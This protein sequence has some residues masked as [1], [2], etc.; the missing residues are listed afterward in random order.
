MFRCKNAGWRHNWYP[1]AG[2]ILP[3]LLLMSSQT[4]GSEPMYMPPYDYSEMSY[5]GLTDKLHSKEAAERESAAYYL[6]DRLR[7]N[8]N[9]GDL[10]RTFDALK[11]ALASEKSI[12][13]R[14]NIWASISNMLRGKADSPSA[15]LFRD[16]KEF[17]LT[18][19]SESDDFNSVYQALFLVGYHKAE[20]ADAAV[21]A[22]LSFPR[23]L[24]RIEA[25]KTAVALNLR[26]AQPVL[27]SMLREPD[28]S[29]SLHNA[30]VRALGKIG[31]EAS[32]PE[33]LMRR[34]AVK[35]KGHSVA[36]FDMAIAE[37]K[38]RSAREKPE[39]LDFETIKEHSIAEDE[40][41]RAS[42]AHD[43]TVI[44]NAA[45][46]GEVERIEALLA[47]NPSL[48]HTT[49]S[50]NNLTPLHWAA[51]RGRL[52]AVILLLDHGAEVD[53]E[54]RHGR[55]PLLLTSDT[56]I[57][58]LLLESGADFR[59]VD[60]NGGSVLHTAAFEGNKELVEM[61]IE[62]GVD[63]EQE[64]VNGGSALL[65]AASRE[66]KEVVALLLEKGASVEARDTGGETVLHKA[67]SAIKFLTRGTE[68]SG[69]VTSFLLEKGLEVDVRDN[70]GETPLHEAADTVHFFASAR[71]LLDHGA[72]V[73][74]KNNE[75]VMPLHLASRYPENAPLIKLLLERGADV[76]ATD[77]RGETALLVAARHVAAA[78]RGNLEG[79]RLLLKAGADISV[80]DGIQDLTAL[81]IAAGAGVPEL[82]QLLL[83]RGA[84]VNAT[85]LAY[86]KL[87]RPAPIYG[88]TPLHFAVG[89]VRRRGRYYSGQQNQPENAADM[90]VECVRLLLDNGAVVNAADSR[91]MTPLDFAHGPGK[92]EIVKVL[93]E[94][95][96]K[97]GQE[98]Q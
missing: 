22:A 95:G 72:N 74:A 89:G 25:C 45:R 86:P 52:L 85:A 56:E 28:E 50:H 67:A 17:W 58:R 98:L 32:M 27:R 71:I 26:S 41:A 90:R 97:Y 49:L 64:Y 15:R 91:G 33:L 40:E 83:A 7:W 18:I 55:T 61:W 42:F 62:K 70:A 84:D 53:A 78:H 80:K 59:H 81:H 8:F 34:A 93:R 5:D 37:I 68:H 54:D 96:G 51:S 44:C 19:L 11:L 73:N 82:V 66:H 4:V 69:V 16:N 10:G 2:V 24:V 75:D 21:V 39:A 63:L 31:T 87:S 20:W 1:F 36:D 43:S 46:E 35:A 94:H 92:D 38:Q 65:C 13:V 23:E 12:Q 79:I 3:C 77:R 76:N 57:A 88:R 47:K 9:L 14:S 30:C 60:K 6:G 48:V 29:G